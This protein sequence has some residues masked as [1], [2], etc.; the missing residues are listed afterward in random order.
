ME[1]LYGP[2]SAMFVLFVVTTITELIKQA[3][4]LKGYQVQ[5]VSL[6]VSILVI[7][8]YQVITSLLGFRDAAIEPEALDIAWI[9]YKSALYSIAGWLTSIG[10]FEVGSKLWLSLKERA[11]QRAAEEGANQ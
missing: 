5:L 9:A 7:T 10:M 3:K 4:S 11:E 1:D 2:I 8:P 6:G